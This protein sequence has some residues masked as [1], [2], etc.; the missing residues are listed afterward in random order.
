MVDGKRVLLFQIPAAPRGIP[1]GW[2]GHFYARKGESLT[3]LDMSK[4]EEIRRQTVEEDWSAVTL[5]DVTLKDLDEL[6]V[7]KA[8]VMYKK[9]HSRIDESEIDSWSV[10]ELLGNSGVM[11]DG[12]LTRAAIILLGKPTSVYKLRPAV[13]EVTWTLKDEKD[14]V[15]DYEHFTAPFIMTVD[16]ILAKIRNL[17]MRELPGGTLFPDTMKQY[18]DYSIREALHNAIAHQ[19]YTLHE[20]INFVESPGSLYYENGGSFIPGTLQKALAMKGPQRFFRNKCLCEGMVNFNMIDTVS[21]GIKKIFGEQLRRH[22]PMPDYEIDDVHKV[23]GV[24]LYGNVINEKYTQVLKENKSLSLQECIAL[25][26]IQKGHQ[27]SE[28]TA[29]ELLEKGLIEGES[30]N[31][32]IS[33]GVAKMTHQLPEYTRVSGLE[34]SKLKQMTLQFVQNAGTDGAKREDIY[35]YLKDAMPGNKTKEQHLR[36]LGNL[37]KEMKDEK[38]VYSIGLSWY[39]SSL[40]PTRTD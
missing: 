39:D 2:Q 35:A 17:T 32:Q 11:I 29:R 4:Y 30:P 25:D 26:A 10:E 12:K 6:A 24:R 13:V 8:R 33:L 7:A 31:Y 27:I 23:V 40:N 19:D 18:D 3:A 15:V 20:R 34:R 14:E 9:V 22:F 36:L 1:M 16:T 28:E 21:R 38:T 5:D 37:L